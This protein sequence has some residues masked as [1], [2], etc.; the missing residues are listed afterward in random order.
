MFIILYTIIR[1]EK[2]R[3]QW[4]NTQKRILAGVKAQKLH[5]KLNFQW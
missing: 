4:S 3:S 1:R 2:K 5:E